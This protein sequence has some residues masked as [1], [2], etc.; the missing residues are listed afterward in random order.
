MKM[1]FIVALK[2]RNVEEMHQEFLDV[3][4]PSTSKYGNFLSLESISSRFGPRGEDKAKVVDFFASIPGA[5][6]DDGG[7]YGDMISVSAP[8]ANVENFLKTKLSFKKHKLALSPKRALRA[9]APLTI[10]RDIEEHISFV[11]LN[12]P[13]MHVI[14]NGEKWIKDE[15]AKAGDEAASAVLVSRGN[16][17]ALISFKPVCQDGSNNDANPP[18][19]NVGAAPSFTISISAHANNKADPYLLNTDSTVFTV[20]NANVFCYNAYN[21]GA[22]V[23][24]NNGFNGRNCTCL[25]KVTR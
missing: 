20:P 18:C 19:A 1:K 12:S 11:S 15:K 22:C 14:A 17:E 16:E 2:L 9:D 25:T 13:V 4:M 3:S 23:P 7:K 6:I 24:G 10:P 8:I 5:T 21:G